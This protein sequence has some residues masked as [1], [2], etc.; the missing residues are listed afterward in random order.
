M[1]KYIQFYLLGEVKCTKW[2]AKKI[3]LRYF[4][5]ICLKD[6][7]V[8][9][10]ITDKVEISNAATRHDGNCSD[11][12]Y[13]HGYNTGVPLETWIFELIHRKDGSKPH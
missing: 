3:E 10:S 6:I 12:V 4:W 2:V 8:I 11:F 9:V 5:R 1:A 7:G 13:W